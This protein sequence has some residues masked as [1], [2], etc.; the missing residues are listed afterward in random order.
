MTQK[1][2]CVFRRTT[3]RVERYKARRL[4]KTRKQ[5]ERYAMQQKEDFDP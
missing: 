5:E 2:K 4:E 3:D 1:K